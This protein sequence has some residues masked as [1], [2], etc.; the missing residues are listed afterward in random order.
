M[1]KLFCAFLAAFLILFSGCDK[2]MNNGDGRLVIKITDAPFPIDNIEAATV[3]ITKVEIRKAGDCISDGNP[4]LVA[5][6][7]TEVFNLLELRNGLVEE[8]IDTGLVD[9]IGHFDLI[10]KFGFRP[11]E[12]F[13]YLIDTICKKLS[14]MDMV[15]EINASGLDRPCQEQYPSEEILRKLLEYNIK[16]TFGSDAHKA[17]EVGRYFNEI[18]TLLK[19]IGFTHIC[20]FE[21]RKKI[22]HKI[23]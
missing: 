21:K 7:G 15:V 16:I 19:E 6:E 8:L 2:T 12:K 17:E 18:M 3:T 4:F 20:S 10:K 9:I 1:K 22:S 23:D 13:D 14:E 11:K 5:W